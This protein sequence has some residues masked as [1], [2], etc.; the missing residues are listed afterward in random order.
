MCDRCGE[1]KVRERVVNPRRH[2]GD[3]LCAALQQL[4]EEVN[5]MTPEARLEQYRRLRAERLEREA[6]EQAVAEAAAVEEE[7]RRR[8]AEQARHEQERLAEEERKE[9]QRRADR[10]ARWAQEGLCAQC[11]TKPS[12]WDRLVRFLDVDELCG[13]CRSKQ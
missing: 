6:R 1:T 4:R 2:L 11:G 13:S 12:L 9:Q 3:V 7:E 5:A 8:V 10:R